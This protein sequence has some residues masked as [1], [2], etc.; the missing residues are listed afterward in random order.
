MQF[1]QPSS[2]QMYATQ[3]QGSML[4]RTPFRTPQNVIEE[5]KLARQMVDQDDD[6][7]ATI[8]YMSNIAFGDGMRNQHPDEKTQALFNRIARE[9]NLDYVWQELYRE[10]LISSQVN[11]VTIFT[12]KRLTF[13]PDGTEDT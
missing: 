9:M 5:I 3:G 7:K 2:F 12:R 6:L 13:N 8:Q 10:W 11:T 4:A 1:G